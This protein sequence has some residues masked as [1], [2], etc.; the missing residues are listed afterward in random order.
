M[1]YQL[2]KLVENS[3][4]LD[5]FISER[6]NSN[7]AYN[8][9]FMHKLYGVCRVDDKPYL[10]KITVE[11][12]AN[13]QSGTLMRMYNFQDIKIEPIRLIEFTEEQLARSVLNGSDISTSELFKVVKH[14]DNDFYINHSEQK[15]QE[16]S[17]VLGLQSSQGLNA[18]DSKEPIRLIEFTEEQ[19]ARSVLKGS[20][21]S[22]SDLFKVVKHYDNDFYINHSEQKSQELFS[23]L[24]LQLSKGLNILDSDVIIHQSRD[25][26]KGMQQENNAEQLSFFE[27]STL[28]DT[29]VEIPFAVGDEIDYGERH[30]TI[31]KIDKE[32]NTVTLLDYNTGWYPISHDEDLSMV[33]AEFEA[34]REKE[35]AG[36]VNIT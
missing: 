20:N 16:L 28:E 7:K 32:K 10:A 14:Y 5:S 24:G 30:Y 12:F 11:E 35:I 27:N 36:F 18:L 4:L 21:I 17:S 9:A 25:I 15:S 19:L 34:V 29:E 3:I 33:I 23:V 1:L 2:P 13:G 8:T 22:I 31:S 26:V 6:N